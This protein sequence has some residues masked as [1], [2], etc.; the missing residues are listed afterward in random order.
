MQGISAGS[1]LKEPGSVWRTK[2]NECL[3]SRYSDALRRGRFSKEGELLIPDHRSYTH[4]LDR[5]RVL[6]L[7]LLPRLLRAAVVVVLRERATEPGHAGLADRLLLED[8]HRAAVVVR[9]ERQVGV[10]EYE[11]EVG[12]GVGGDLAQLGADFLEPAR[13]SMRP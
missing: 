4:N 12:T 10:R 2:V 1:R 5:P 13:V 3:C 8:L 6:R 11:R 7:L 9:P